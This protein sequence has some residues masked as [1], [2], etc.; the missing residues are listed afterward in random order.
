MPT[1]RK[2]AIIEDLTSKVNQSKMAVMV[3]YTGMTVAQ[4]T[5]ARNQLRKQNVELKVVKNTLFREATRRARM[6]GLDGLF[7][8]ANAVA[9]VY[10]NESAATRAINDLVRTTRGAVS[11]RSGIVGGRLMAPEDVARIADLPPREELLAR[12]V[13]AI[14]APLTT[15]LGTLNAPAQQMA[16][17]LAALQQQKEGGSAA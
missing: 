13:G 12:A 9:F 10:D 15:L 2:A 4:L 3:T 8:Q 5:D 7:T 1:E 16:L 11:I 14:A 17:V 6:E